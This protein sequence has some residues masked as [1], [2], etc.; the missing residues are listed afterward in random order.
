M[1]LSVLML[2]STVLGAGWLTRLVPTARTTWM[3]PLLAFSG[4]YLF[5][6]TITHLLP[7]ALTLTPHNT[8]RVGY[9]VLAGFFGQLLLEVFSQGVEHGHIHH[10]THHA[11]RVPYLL[12]SALVIHSFFEGSI[13][14]RNPETEG[15]GQNF[16]AITAGIALHHIPAAFALMAAL[17]MRLNSFWRALPYLVLFAL[18]APAGII[19]SNYVV[20]DE[21]LSN[22]WYAALLGL[23]AGNFLHVSTTILFETSPDHHLN[24]RKLVATLIGALL[25]LAVDWV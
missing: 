25:A 6:L 20:L 22:G 9:F 4:A 14:V 24:V 7:E 12:L 5:T 23:V 17:L 8:H 11:G 16:Y 19:V 3:K 13:L 18:A 15:V 2:F 21:L 1:W 10:Q